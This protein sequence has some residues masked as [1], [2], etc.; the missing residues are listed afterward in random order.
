MRPR[1]EIALWVSGI[2]AVVIIL[3]RALWP[4]AQAEIEHRSPYQIDGDQQDELNAI[5][6]AP[7]VPSGISLPPL[8]SLKAPP[9]Y[10]PANEYAPPPNNYQPPSD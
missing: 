5:P 9:D 6:E 8:Q 2:L 10:T 4:I 3:A 7:P 1:S